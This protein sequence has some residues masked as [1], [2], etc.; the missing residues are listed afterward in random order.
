MTILR[1][2]EYQALKSITLSGAVVD[3]GGD[4]RSE[5]HKL[6]KG[7]FS[8]TTANLEGTKPDVV[9]DLEKPLPFTKSSYDGALLINVL[10]HIFEYRQLI[11]ESARVLK[12]GG[13]IIIVVP[14]LFPYHPSPSDFHRYSGEA[15]TKALLSSGF[16]NISV[17][18]LG[19]GVFAVRWVLLERLLPRF[20]QPLSLFMNPLARISDYLFAKFAGLLGKKY[21]PSDYP[22]GY[23]VT[24]LKPQ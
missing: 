20:L 21:Q 6:F 9:V 18:P 11:G 3:L 1:K 22:L 4:S 16:S 23:L 19:T 8:I 2:A 13:S 10:E 5:Y 15:L 12:P 24:A 14:F 7:D 17:T